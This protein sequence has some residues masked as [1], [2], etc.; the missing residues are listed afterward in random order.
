MCMKI[1]QWIEKNF[2]DLDGKLIAITGASGDIGR[3]LCDILGSR[4]ANLLLINRSESKT[5]KL[6]E[7]LL[8]KYDIKINS[9]LIDFENFES[10]KNGLTEIAKYKI[11][12]LILNA[13]AYKIERR[14]SDIGY[15]NVFQINFVSQYYLARKVLDNGCDHLVAVSSIAHNYSKINLEDIDFSLNNKASKVYGNSKRFLM[16][17]L[18][19]LFKKYND[20]TLS[21]VHPGITYTNIT[22][23]YPKIIFKIIKYPMK[24]I[25]ARLRKATVSIAVGVY[26]KCNYHEWIG[27]K[28]FN[29]WGLPKKQLV[30]TC[31]N[32]ESVKI[33]EIAEDIF[34][35]VDLL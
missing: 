2:N 31:S 11:D 19:E 24:V 12:T 28:I 17:S 4:R 22:S 29:V 33:G 34:N 8:S 6:K 15:D 23:H 13:G 27:P 7:D 3:E 20:K 21:I 1:N 9:V 18:Y 14:K 35:K 30:K 10:V 32:E 26:N 5:N 16:F 25:F